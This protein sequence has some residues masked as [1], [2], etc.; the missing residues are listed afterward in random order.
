MRLHRIVSLVVVVAALALAA[1][2]TLAEGYVGISGGQSDFELDQS[3]VRFNLDGTSYKAFGGFKFKPWIAAELQYAS[4]DG[5]ES[6]VG[7]IKAEFDGDLI[8]AFAVVSARIAPRVEVWAKAGGTVWDTS[9]TLSVP[10]EPAS[11]IDDDGT[12]FSYG[13]GVAFLATR[14]FGVRVEWET[15]GDLGDAKSVKFVSAGLQYTF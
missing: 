7:D 4:I 14:R 1:P 15:F 5:L 3:S 12:E 6:T 9:V 10:D 8:S 11:A 13:V 2:A